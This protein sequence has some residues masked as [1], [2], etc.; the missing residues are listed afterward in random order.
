MA[1]HLEN[2]E[3]SAENIFDEKAREI[4]ENL[5]KSVENEIVLANDLP[6]SA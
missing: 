3:E 4:H 6:Y 5:S 2:R 1:A